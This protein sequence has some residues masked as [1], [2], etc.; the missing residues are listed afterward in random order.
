MGIV[1]LPQC[2]DPIITVDSTM[3]VSI[4]AGIM[5]LV[6]GMVFMF[7]LF[8]IVTSQD[9]GNIISGGFPW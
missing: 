6:L 7:G 9:I 2:G 3:A 5:A 4:T 8:F 1:H